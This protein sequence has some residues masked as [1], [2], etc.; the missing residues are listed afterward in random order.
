MRFLKN[1][2][3]N[4][5]NKT[6]LDYGATAY[7]TKQEALNGRSSS[8]AIEDMITE[9]GTAILPDYGYLKHDKEIILYRKG[10]SVIGGCNL[11]G[12]GNKM[13]RPI[14]HNQ[15]IKGFT[16]HLENGGSVVYV[17]GAHKGAID[18]NSAGKE[19]HK[20][21]NRSRVINNEWNFN[22]ESNFTGTPVIIDLTQD[23]KGFGYYS[24][25]GFTDIG[26]N[27]TNVDRGIIIKKMKTDIPNG[28]HQAL[29]TINIKSRIWGA[30]KYADISSINFSTIDI[31]AQH[32]GEL[33][34]SIFEV[35]GSQLKSNIFV[36]DLPSGFK[37]GNYHVKDLDLSGYFDILPYPVTSQ[38]RLNESTLIDLHPKWDL[39]YYGN[40]E[41]E[42]REPKTVQELLWTLK[43]SDLVKK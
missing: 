22:V 5:N 8:Q 10:D 23:E 42:P 31:M 24:H 39:T 9:W 1:L 34:G 7:K 25:V 20:W 38:A 37:A 36:Y 4:D 29:N 30:R 43:R 18:I 27:W 40:N 41:P 28:V 21:A 2:F 14:N 6:I 35:Q 12:N 19:Y 32:K 11:V 33:D 15:T 13:F 26:G 16:A 17:G 3:S